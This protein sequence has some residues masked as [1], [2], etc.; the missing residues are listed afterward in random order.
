[1]PAPEKITD[2]GVIAEATVVDADLFELIDLSASD[3]VKLSIGT[4]KLILAS[5]AVFEVSASL[6]AVANNVALKH[7]EVLTNLT[8]IVFPMDVR[9]IGIG[10]SSGAS[11]T[12][13]LELR[14]AGTLIPG[15]FL[16]TT[17]NTKAGTTALAVNISALT[18]IEVFVNGTGIIKPQVTLFFAR[19]T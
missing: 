2:M 18:E 13:T 5:F 9:L 15:A 6:D 10:A 16:T 8:P 14:E 12:W 7:G 19:R 11:A 3:N 17:A 1:M 4:L